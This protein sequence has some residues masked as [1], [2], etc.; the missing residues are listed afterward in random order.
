MSKPGDRYAQK[1]HAC[2]GPH[3]QGRA[4]DVLNI[5]L[6]N[7]LGKVDCANAREAARQLLAERATHAF[8]PKS[9]YQWCGG[10]SSRRWRSNWVF[11]LPIQ[12]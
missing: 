8:P 5:L 3:A 6:I 12:P 10:L 2:T 11:L 7:L 9:P 1:L 4:R